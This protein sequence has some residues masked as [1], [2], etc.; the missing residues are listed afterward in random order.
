MGPYTRLII[1]GDDFQLQSVGPGNILF[2]LVEYLDVPTVRLTKIFRQSEGS[3]ILDYANDLRLNTFK[4]PL[5]PKVDKGDIVFISETNNQRQQ[6]IALSLYDKAYD[7]YGVENIML[8]TPTNKGPSGRGILNKK[9]QSIING[10]ATPLD[11]VFGA[12]QDDEDRKT[13]YRSGDYITVKSNNYN[14]VTDDDDITEIINGDLG[15]VQYTTG[16]EL[17][18]EVN[19]HYFTIDKSEI[20]DLID[21]A[22]AIT[23]HKSQGGQA[24]EVIIVLPKNCYFNLNA[25]ML[26]TAITR[27]KTKCYVIGDFVGIN[28]AAGK[29]ANFS[30][31]TMIQLKQLAEDK[32]MADLVCRNI[33]TLSE[34]E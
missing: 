21:H 23:I 22:W 9:V 7:K 17:T 1:V 32:E 30:R 15:Y 19:D 5:M 13:F 34:K 12:N 20:H 29:Q 26:Y 16:K 33:V 10:N 31:K 28:E 3:G 8:L 18:F 25:N 24:N 2:D 4:L 11:V 6:E 14:M 27:A